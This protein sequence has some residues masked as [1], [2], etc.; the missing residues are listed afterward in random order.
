M[1]EFIEKHKEDGRIILGIPC[2]YSE[3]MI[4]PKHIF[5]YFEGGQIIAKCRGNE[6][7]T[8]D[9]IEEYTSTEQI[10]VDL[11]DLYRI[12]IVEYTSIWNKRVDALKLRENGWVKVKMHRI[13]GE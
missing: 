8:L 7:V 9:L 5:Q 10:E 12:G 2:K 6:L 11:R 13:E 1:S 3:I 4:I